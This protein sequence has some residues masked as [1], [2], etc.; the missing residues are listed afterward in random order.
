MGNIKVI[1]GENGKGKT[2]YLLNYYHINKQNRRI[3]I[4]SNSLI[5]PFP[6]HRNNSKHH[7]FDLRAR[8]SFRPG[9]FS[10]SIRGYF[11]RLLSSHPTKD[12]F[13]ILDHIGFDDEFIIIRKPLYKIR[14]Y[15]SNLTNKKIYSLVPSSNLKD[16]YYPYHSTY[17]EREITPGYAEK[18][19]PILES[20]YEFQL[21]YDNH[22]I[23]HQSYLDHLDL[24]REIKHN[25]KSLR[26]H[27]LFKTEF[28]FKKDN[29]SF[30]L[31]HASSGELNILALG[32]FIKNFLGSDNSLDF[33]K[34]ILIDEP[35]NSLH[36]KWQ[37]EYI[38]FLQGF[39]GYKE[40]VDVIIATHSP[41]IAMDNYNYAKRIDLMEVID[42][43]L[44][45]IQHNS[46]HN[47]IEQIYYELFKLL[48]PKN[49]FLSDYCNNLL[50]D[51]AERK[52]SYDAAYKALQSM[53][54]ASFDSQQKKFL[55]DVIV[56][57]KK[58]NGGIHG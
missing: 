15:I 19:S 6:L 41:L 35:E 39:I 58:V 20:T 30:P 4:I 37:R 32:L 44:Y 10:Q 25:I 53:S 18:I 34:T 31:E 38:G 14:S 9:F 24:E 12:L 1:L 42:G 55:K 27:S 50:K 51:F 43:N 7:Y 46:Q 11:S 52:V 23:Q 45:P 54:L 48:T 3:A 40:N 47:N 28:F 56:L 33:P 5:N 16:D 36:P 57:L 29:I 13:Y 49:R 2:R 22:E 17:E 26:L 8:D 21:R